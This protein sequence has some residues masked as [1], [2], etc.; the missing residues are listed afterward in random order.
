MLLCNTKKLNAVT[1]APAPVAASAPASGVGPGASILGVGA[2]ALA[3]TA[4][5]RP[6]KR[7]AKKD[8]VV[9][10]ATATEVDV[11]TECINAIRFLAVD[12]VNKA[13]SGHPGAP[14]GQA[15]IGYL[16]FAEEMQY[17]PEDPKWVNRDRFVLSSGHGCM[18]QYSLLHLAGY[19]SVSID[20][21]KQFRQWGS[22]TP[23]HPENFET[24]GIEV[25]LDCN[26]HVL[27][28]ACCS[29]AV[30][31]LRGFVL[32]AERPRPFARTTG[33][34][35]MGI[36]NAVG[37]AAAEAHL[38]AVTWH[39]PR[40]GLRARRTA[41][42]LRLSVTGLLNGIRRGVCGFWDSMVRSSFLTIYS[43]TV[44]SIGFC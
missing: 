18:L 2:A 17:N 40:R 42:P 32:S 36:S 9:R 20:D 16:L 26:E 6:N 12:A 38:A 22:K 29:P 34:L 27:Q 10:L 23:G 35:G 7:C 21:I 28:I 37:L 8:K 33:P 1:S 43:I 25:Q 13:N 15:P 5:V 4:A 19:D 30:R 39:P 3:A 11:D 31:L 14:M 41:R 44:Y 24:D